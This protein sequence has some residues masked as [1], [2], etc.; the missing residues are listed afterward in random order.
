MIRDKELILYREFKHRDI[1]DDAAFIAASEN[2]SP[3]VLKETMNRFTGS[4]VE[5]AVSHGYK[6]NLWC[7]YLTY[8]I[9]NCEN[10]YSTSCEMR[11]ESDGTLREVALHDFSIFREMFALDLKE[12][13]RKC[14]TD[15]AHLIEDYSGTDER[16]RMFN[17]R[18]RDRI[19]ELRDQLY[20]ATDDEDFAGKVAQFYKELRRPLNRC[21]LPV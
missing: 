19:I 5:L 18:I 17:K 13:D 3:D 7:A 21:R 9:A 8:L 15:N 2:G 14:Q 4:L 12:L 16:S 20:E 11:G 10:A 6:G 1:L